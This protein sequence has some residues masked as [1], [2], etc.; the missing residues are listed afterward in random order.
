M[1]KWQQRKTQPKMQYCDFI[2][3]I[4]YNHPATTRREGGGM[5]GG[6]GWQELEA[7]KRKCTL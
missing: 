3:Q 5:G 6:S 2:T 1:G 7:K 4:A